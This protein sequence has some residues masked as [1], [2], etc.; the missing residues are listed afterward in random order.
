VLELSRFVFEGL[1]KDRDSVLYRGRSK[2]D[3]SRILVLVPALERPEPNRL[4][5][6]ENE[7]SLREELD[8]AWAARP[9]ALAQHWDRT[10]LVLEDPGGTP[11]D[12]LLV[13]PL[14]IAFALRLATSF[15]KS[16]GH[17]HERGIIHRDIKPS[18]VLVNPVTGQVWFTGFGIAS[19]LPRERQS[20]EP[21]EFIAGTLPYMAPEQTG[22]MNRSVD[23]R[24]DLYSLGVI[25]YE[26]LTGTLPF[27]ASDPMGWVHCHIARQP[28][29]PA[30]R[31]KDIPETVSAIVLRLLAKTAEERYQTAAGLEFDL[32]R[33]LAEWES[34]KRIE[35]F[36]LGT[37]DISDR[38]LMPEKLYG[39][40]RESRILLESFNQV[41]A[42]GK[43]IL[44]LVS[45][46]SGI[47]KSAIVSEL[48]KAIVLPRGIFI[49]GKFD[50]YKRDIPYATLAQ[51]LQTLVRQI[52]GKSDT[53]V[54]HWRELLQEALG[55]NAQLIANLIPEIELVI[56]KQPPVSE[57]PPMEAETRFHT[58]FRSFLSVFARKD[59]PLVLF[60]DDLQWLD[61]AT[62]KLLEHFMTQPEVGHLLVIGAFRDNEVGSD[63][64]LL[65]TLE[66]IRQTQAI[67][68]EIV[69]APLSLR[70]LIEFVADTLRCGQEA[71]AS[72]ARL[73]H[74]KTLGNPFFSVQFLTALREEHLLKFNAR[75][76]IWMWDLKQIRTKGYTDNVVDLMAGK[77]N[78]LPEKT[79]ESLKQLACL[80]NQADFATLSLLRAER[81]EALDASL[82]EALHAGYVVRIENSYK[83]LH[84]RVQE[85]AYSLIP[86]E[87]RP[88]THLR[89]GRLV[90]AHTEPE[91]IEERIFEIVNQFNLGIDLI[92]ESE[93]REQVAKFNLIAGKRA[94]NSTAYV[95]A[96]RYL[97]AGR[98]LLG[99]DYR[100]SDCPLA[101]LTDLPSPSSSGREDNWN[102]G[103]ARYDLT[104]A[105]ELHIAQ[106]EYLTGEL[107]AAEERLSLLSAHAGDLVDFATVTAARLELYTTQGRIDRAVEVCLD[108]LRCVGVN[109]SP[110]P[111]EDEVHAEFERLRSRIGER[112]VESLIDLPSMTD[113]R[114]CA[115]IDVLS[116]LVGPAF[117]TDRNLLA[118]TVGQMA[119]LSLEHGIADASCYGYVWLGIVSGAHFGDYQAG[120]AFGKL[121]FD[122][123]ERGSPLRLKPRV[124]VCFGSLVLPWSKHLRAGIDLVRQA[125]NTAKETGDLNFAGYSC[126]GLLMLLFD[127]GEPLA[128]MRSEAENALRFVT[129]AKFGLMV[130]NIS[131]QL[132]LIRALIGQTSSLGSFNDI[133]FSEERF[134]EQLDGNP[135]F[136]FAASSYWIFKLQA[137][138]HAGDYGAALEASE[139]VKD[140]SWTQLG[141]F[142]LAD[143]HFYSALASAAQY[144]V[145]ADIE[146]ARYA[147][148]LAA[149]HAQLEIWT[150]NCPENFSNRALLVSAEAARVEG[151]EL[152]AMRLYDQAIGAAR[153]NGFVQNEGIA[154]ELA[155]KFY[156]ARGFET[157]ADTYIRNARQCYLR[158]GA[159]GKVR[160]LDELHPH[161]REELPPAL[162]TTTIGTPLEN[163]DLATVVK[164]SQVISGEIVLEKLIEKL[165]QTA[166]EH[167]GAE[168]GILI[169]PRDSEQR[170]EAEARS[171]R[172]K[173]TVHFGQK[174][175]TPSELPDS[176]I[177]YV[178]RTMQSVTLNDASAENLFSEDEYFRRKSARS[179]LCLP[180]VKQCQLTGILYFENNLAPGVFTSNRLATLE[181]IASQAA[182]SLEQARVYAELQHA[183]QELRK[184]EQRLQ[185]FVENSPAV[186]W[187]KDLDLHYLLIN[188]EYERRL[189]VQR[190]QIVGKTDFDL[191]PRDLAEI[192]RAGDRQV[193]EGGVPIQFEEVIPSDEGLGHYIVVKFLLRDSA[194]KPYA[195]CGIA[196][197]I[198]ELK[199]AEELEKKMT[200]E[201]ETF[202]QQRAGQLAKANEAMRGFLD[203]LAVVP[204]LDRFLAQVM[205]AITGQLGAASSTLRLHDVE[206]GRWNVE[207]VF[208]DGRVMSADEAGLPESLRSQSENDV[209]SLLQ[210]G[211]VYRAA[212]PQ[213]AI[214]EELRLYLRSLG[215]ETLLMIPLISRDKPIGLLGLRFADDREFR[216][217]E[218]EIARALATQASLAIQLAKLAEAASQSA[219]L[220]ERNR[221]AGEIHDSL[222]QSFTGI[223]MQ[224]GMAQ[225]VV[226]NKDDNGLSYIERANDLARFGLAE[227]RRSTMSLQPMMFQ[228]SGLIEALRTLVERSN[229]PGKLLCTFRSNFVRD[230]CLPAEVRQGLLRIAQEAIGNAMRHA[231]ST[232]ISV[233]LR[234]DPPNLVLEVKDNGSGMATESKASDGFGLANMRARAKKL[235]GSLKI[236]TAS[237]CGTSIIVSLPIN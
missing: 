93:E 132:Q 16:I 166:I 37:H 225:E 56:G 221:M 122:L 162:P 218:L 118:L 65:R 184:S 220:N 145:A 138:F 205:V 117:F 229:I 22:R 72:L 128:N 155:A 54:G 33:C 174:L 110:H 217:D 200:R 123:V 201:R 90:A 235:K 78:R 35:A 82:W 11:L 101:P 98:V 73:V 161:L 113:R 195:T 38:L 29:P 133:Q 148:P 175:V 42:T 197:D 153:E 135:R 124:Y 61:R 168:R 203:A 112:P 96:L 154:N 164:V 104:F 87:D 49:S 18:N 69:L 204:E 226:M 5:R 120:Y 14:E 177:R 158:W 102:R 23:S 234:S 232:A 163:L 231:R 176:L 51:A 63:H 144:G 186:V 223:S 71:A 20:P 43:P 173:V 25:L 100:Q 12:Q 165:M 202:V 206:T 114:W 228:E 146:R 191:F 24:S 212:E 227:A 58:V 99:E 84:D 1:R 141:F 236:R 152:A 150:K 178:V 107:D 41:V 48:H 237:G 136:A 140:L 103:S 45:G 193:L 6:L 143:Y 95:S 83:F 89:I 213:A 171:D 115:T 21:P 105:F 64:A 47:G 180:L 28:V 179:V 134:E 39:R 109:W 126:S 26:M 9:I 216:P 68:R 199:R 4:K 142:H 30:Q 215:A 81:E 230:E 187:V 156:A 116:L 192:Y 13:C 8:P 2:G 170:I 233:T 10:V 53:E 66:A 188:R 222:A 111:S 34:V 127:A 40:D 46:Y 86:Q 3:P 77:L 76:G 129:K 209:S 172:D 125:F 121:A 57:I 160:Q 183:N 198:T 181:L 169:L 119:S 32:G 157:I 31:A 214:F 196:T 131:P 36:T 219:V 159:E 15:A 7:Y 79:Q 74:K 190:D 147:K 185:D 85:A 60:L 67:V 59:H 97:R 70:D 88:S 27:S 151:R 182:I 91:L 50:Q 17:L 55:T 208:Q 167:A 19:R 92:T 130:A 189:H 106:C 108:Y 149:H 52:L 211:V 194:G 62:L 139:K 224:L 137:Y 44:V 94:Q 80:G 207:L 75:N 210:G